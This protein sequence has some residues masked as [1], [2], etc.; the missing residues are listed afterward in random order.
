MIK[1][2]L[3]ITVCLYLSSCSSSGVGE[4]A[5]ASFDSE[6]T[7]VMC[8]T[9]E[10]SSHNGEHFSVKDV[11][12]S[13]PVVNTIHGQAFMEAD[14]FMTNDGQRVSINKAYPPVAQLI[15]E[16]GSIKSIKIRYIESKSD[17]KPK[18]SNEINYSA[19]HQSDDG[20][21]TQSSV[22]IRI[23]DRIYDYTCWFVAPLKRF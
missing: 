13:T 14:M 11:G 8:G 3:S 6:E 19:H 16:D 15:V 18:Y 12:E 4:R 5:V 1:K 17:Q 23:K 9:R 20:K 2:F 7:G 10:L 21:V 22:M